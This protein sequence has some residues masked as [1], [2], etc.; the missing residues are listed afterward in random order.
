MPTQAGG[1]RTRDGKRV[2]SVTTICNRFKESGGLIHWAWAL[3]YEP[4]MQARSL[5]RNGANGSTGAFLAIPDE[6][7]DYRAARDR[8]ADAGTIAH[9]MVDSFV[10]GREFDPMVYDPAL[11]ELARPAFEAFREWAASSSF[12]AVETEVSLVSEI[13]RYGGTRD[14]ILVNG[15]RAMG[16]WKTSNAIYPE[17]LLQLAAYAILDE[18][19]G[20]AIDGGFHLLK[21]SKQ[22]KPD[23]PVRFAH[24]YW[25]QLDLAKRGF[26]LLREAYSIMSD[27]GKLVK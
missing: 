9:E 3:S 2:P 13:H 14:A 8:A 24:F 22:E 17:Y 5:L 21:F 25:D 16:D 23:D 10:K 7:F 15:K 11:V 19:A 6:T 12:K 4:L 1:Y 18:E 20:N 27:L 26:L